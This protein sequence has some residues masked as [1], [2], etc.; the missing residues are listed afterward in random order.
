[1]PSPPSKHLTWVDLECKDGTSY[2]AEWRLTRLPALTDAFERVRAMYNKPIKVV[3]AYRTESHNR[4]I[5]GARHSQHVQGRALDLKPPS[6]VSVAKFYSD[7]K[8]NAWA[9]GIRGIGLYKT[10]VHIDVRPNDTRLAVWTGHGVKD[11]A[12]NG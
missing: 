8:R 3:S 2:P 11:S 6:G 4:S 5:G 1:M 9:F 12:S 10:F 7:I